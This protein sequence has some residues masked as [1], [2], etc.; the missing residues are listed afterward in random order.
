MSQ[1][2]ASFLVFVRKAPAG[3]VAFGPPSLDEDLNAM[4]FAF[5]AAAK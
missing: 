2:G 5:F 3:R 4:Y 1:V